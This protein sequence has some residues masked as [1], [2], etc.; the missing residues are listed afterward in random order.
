MDWQDWG[1]LANFLVLVIGG[2]LFLVSFAGRY[3]HEQPKGWNLPL[4]VLGVKV[5]H[6]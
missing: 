2:I 5:C 3:V 4:G 6:C 1:Y